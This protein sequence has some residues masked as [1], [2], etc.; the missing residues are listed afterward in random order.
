MFCKLLTVTCVL[1]T[2]LG[3]TGVGLWHE[4]DIAIDSCYV[5]N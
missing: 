4:A 1:T 3:I 2:F 5:S